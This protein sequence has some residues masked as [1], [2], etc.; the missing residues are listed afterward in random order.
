MIIN[1]NESANSCEFIKVNVQDKNVEE[2]D[3]VE[4]SFSKEALVGFAKSLIW[5]YEDTDENEKFY[6]CT[7]P[8]GG[9]PSGNQV[10]GF[11]LTTG[12]PVLT[13]D[14]NS[15]DCDAIK[16]DDENTVYTKSQ[17][18]KFIEI[19]PPA[20]D[21]TLMEEYELGFRNLSK[22]T[23]Y[24]KNQIDISENYYE[25]FFK[26]NYG[27]LKN[28]AIVLLKLADGYKEGKEYIL[29]QTGKNSKLY[30]WGIA[31]T[32]DS[33]PVKLK[34]CNLGSVYDYEADFG[35]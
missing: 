31:L 9:V 8:L 4:I 33:L 5:M 13:F 2:I 18:K 28:L 25:V 27:G 14:V 1:L 32:H 15:L 24:N 34:L 6:F 21:A 17:I 7:D 35:Q 19:L 30:E 20:L 23:L 22:I 3:I 16:Y 29:A 26:I 11:Y 12:S 10:V